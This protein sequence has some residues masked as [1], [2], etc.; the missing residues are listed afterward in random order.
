MDSSSRLL[1]R[2]ADGA[3]S[4]AEAQLVS[5]LVQHDAD[6]RQR[7][8]VISS[9]D[10]ALRHAY[11]PHQGARDHHDQVLQLIRNRLP[12]T[13]P[14]SSISLTLVDLVYG[15]MLVSL[16]GVGY[17]LLG[18]LSAQPVLLLTIAIFSLIGGLALTVLAGAVR[19]LESSVLGSL[20]HRRV[21][22]GSTDVLVYRAIGIGMAMGGLWLTR[23][24]G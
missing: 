1:Q 16:M 3:A 9:L 11:R 2:F 12:T 19:R 5:H 7:L 4:T 24:A 6:T 23:L 10:N 15:I 20:L 14:K 8:A 17:G 21:T 18:S 22:V 13:I